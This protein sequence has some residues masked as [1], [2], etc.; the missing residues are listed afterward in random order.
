MEA[1]GA[2]ERGVPCEKGTRPL[3]DRG[4]RQLMPLY[5]FLGDS[6]QDAG[7]PSRQAP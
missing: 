7:T 6:V 1:V 3:R 4:E 5:D 2:E